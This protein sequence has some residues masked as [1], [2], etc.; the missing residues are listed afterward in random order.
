MGE[1]GR[2]EEV[3]AS[4]TN[5]IE[6][7]ECKN[8]YPIYD[9]NGGKMAKIDTLFMTKTAERPYPLYIAHMTEYPPYANTNTFSLDVSINTRRTKPFVLL[10]LVLMIVLYT[11]SLCLYFCCAYCAFQ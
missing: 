2:D 4:K 9:Q 10:V 3:A 6:D 11:S 5:R 7:S 8:R 1:G